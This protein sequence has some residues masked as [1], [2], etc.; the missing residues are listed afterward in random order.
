[1]FI[2]LQGSHKKFEEK[3]S[4]WICTIFVLNVS[5]I[6]IVENWVPFI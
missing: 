4:E 6:T 5:L 3:G 2:H 1:M